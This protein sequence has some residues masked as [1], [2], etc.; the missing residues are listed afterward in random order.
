M[1]LVPTGAWTSRG[2]GLPKAALKE[3]L[4]REQGTVSSSRLSGKGPASRVCE[5]AS[6]S[7]VERQG[8][9]LKNGQSV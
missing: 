3:R 8:T 7:T 1:A 2:P 4:S 9:Q 5:T 6:N